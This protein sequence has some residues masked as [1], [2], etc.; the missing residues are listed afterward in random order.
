MFKVGDVKGKVV[1][2][3]VVEAEHLK[4]GG[5][6]AL[7]LEAVDVEAAGVGVLG[8]DMGEGGGVAVE[9]SDDGAIRGEEAA[10]LGGGELAVGGADGVIGEGGD[11][12][13]AEAFVGEVA[14]EDGEGAEGFGGDDVAGGGEDVVGVVGGR[15]VGASGLGGGRGGDGLIGGGE[16]NDTGAAVEEL[17]VGGGGSEPAGLVGFVESDEIDAVSGVKGIDSGGFGGEVVNREETVGE[18]AGESEQGG[19]EG[20]RLMGEAVVVLAPAGASGE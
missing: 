19:D 17:G 18:V 11:V 6:A 8:E 14:A 20:G 1:A 2:G 16:V 13:E 3:G 4:G 9:V 12:D 15:G 7:V 10:E 5:S